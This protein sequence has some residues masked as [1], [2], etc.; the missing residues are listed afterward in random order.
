MSPF[1]KEVLSQLI[2]G[3]IVIVTPIALFYAH[4]ALRMAEKKWGLSL[5]E[6]QEAQLNEFITQG[7]DYAREQTR[8]A[9][10][11]HEAPPNKREQ[12]VYYVERM[13]A[14]KGMQ[15]Q[16]DS[17]YIIAKLEAKLN[18]ERPPEEKE[19]PNA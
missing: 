3:L 15:D 6:T 18:A 14:Q 16:Y 4:K 17:G 10:K 11:G 9:L 12:A 5:N 1:W 19:K 8:K 7:I 13:L 2:D